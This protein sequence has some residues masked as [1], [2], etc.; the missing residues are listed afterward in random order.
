MIN[1][2]FNSDR[3]HQ[4]QSNNGPLLQLDWAVDCEMGSDILYVGTCHFPHSARH[5]WGSR[6]WESSRCNSSENKALGTKLQLTH[7]VGY[8]LHCKWVHSVLL[9]QTSTVLFSSKH[10][11]QSGPPEQI[12]GR[13]PVLQ[14]ETARNVPF[15]PGLHHLSETK[16]AHEIHICGLDLRYQDVWE[17]SLTLTSV[18]N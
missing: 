2:F 12:C 10:D 17:K 1:R 5:L 11:G 13:I 18:E 9:C 15:A 8:F 3:C 14:N 7:W 16:F 4:F 6:S